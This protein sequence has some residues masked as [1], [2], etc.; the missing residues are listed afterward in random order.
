M[1]KTIYQGKCVWRKRIKRRTKNRPVLNLWC[2]A[3]LGTFLA[4]LPGRLPPEDRMRFRVANSRKEYRAEWI[5]PPQ[6]FENHSQDV[7]GIRICPENWEM[8]FY[9]SEEIIRPGP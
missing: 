7:Y 2:M 4:V 1:G 5:L 9:H 8:E 6:N 3:V